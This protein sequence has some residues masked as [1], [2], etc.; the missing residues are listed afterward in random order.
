MIRSGIHHLLY[1]LAQF[2]HLDGKHSAIP[3]LVPIAGNRLIER[4]A[5]TLYTM[6]ENIL[7]PNQ[8]RPV[9]IAFLRC[10]NDGRQL[11]RRVIPRQRFGHHA[12]GRVDVIIPRAP[13]VD[14]VHLARLTNTP[15]ICRRVHES[16]YHRNPPAKLARRSLPKDRVMGFLSACRRHCSRISCG[17]AIAP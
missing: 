17:T 5:Q 4:R 16:A 3:A 15:V 12:A 14:V 8:Q 6:P 9:Q 1:H 10:G 2:V 7:K 13:A 11:H